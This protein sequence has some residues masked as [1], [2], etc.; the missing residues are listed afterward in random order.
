M[1]RKVFFS[2]MP[3]WE[4]RKLMKKG[5]FMK[6][7]LIVVVSLMLIL[8][9]FGGCSSSEKTSA[10]PVH[11]AVEFVDHA[12]SAH[13]ARSQ[14]WFEA[15]GLNVTAFDNYMTGMAMAAALSKGEINAAYICLTPAICA[16]AN[17]AVPI[18]VVAGTH[19][20]GYGLLVDPAKIKTVKDL[21]NPGIRIGC[22]REGSPNDPLLH[23]MIEEYNL[24]EEKILSSVRRMSPSD[25]LMALNMGQLDA[26]FC[27]EQYPTMG[28]ALGF[29]ELLT[30]EDLWPEMQGSVLVVTE[31]LLNNHPEI[32]EKLVKITERGI[33]YILDHP[34]EAAEI[35]A[36]ELSLVGRE[37][38]P[39]DIGDKTD[40]LE[41]TPE[42]I[43]M[44]LTTKMI[45]TTDIDPSIVQENID[46]LVKLGSIKSSFPAEDIL[47]LRFLK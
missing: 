13:I 3:F 26:G 47:D 6:K 32:V 38:M 25:V 8:P 18:K 41:I 17:A 35:V 22:P 19:K 5:I 21:E 16:Y 45:C 2:N 29:K 7:L 9:L 40:Q 39:I 46:Y 36:G 4:I 20:Y 37:I 15:E 10:Y 12:A 23:K 11:L 1:L 33:Q 14:G 42:A 27:C 43:L 31:D 44:S 34:E 28:E 30:A 24:D